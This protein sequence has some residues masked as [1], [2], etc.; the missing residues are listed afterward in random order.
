MTL[1][2]LALAVGRLV[3][4]SIVV[5]EN[6]HRHLHM[7][8]NALKAALDA[9]EEVAMPVLVS[10]LTTI[11]VFF[12]VVFLY[13]MGK[14]LFTPLA[15]SVAFAMAASYAMAMTVVPAA[16]AFLY[17]RRG[18]GAATNDES[19][20]GVDASGIDTPSGGA[21]RRGVFGY[22]GRAFEALRRGYER[23]LLWSVA[24]RGIVL[25]TASVLFVGSLALY[26]FNRSLNR[27]LTPR[28]CAFSNGSTIPRSMSK[29]TES[30]PPI[31]G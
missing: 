7:G 2:G 19:A 22:F 5:L 9:A 30:R 17:R 15:L 25:L 1:G 13:G 18:V 23:T 6:T 12:P 24:N 21:G 11:I 27:F 10:T 8:K 14:Y 20:E 29:W 4:D 26:P 28:T 3:D 31:W 16:M